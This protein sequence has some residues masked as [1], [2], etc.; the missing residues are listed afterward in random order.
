MKSITRYGCVAAALALVALMPVRAEAASYSFSTCLENNSGLC[1]TLVD[2]LHVEVTDAGGGFVDFKFTNDIGI[3]S[4]ITSLYFD[5]T[6]FLT[7]LSIQSQS[8][9]VKFKTTNVTPPN[10]PGAGGATPPFVLTSGL[11]TDSK[12]SGGGTSANGINA[13]TEY[14]TLRMAMAAGKT[15]D[16]I[17][18][19]LGKGDETDTGIRIAAHIQSVGKWDKS[20]SVL[21]CGAVTPTPVPEPGTLALCGVAALAAAYRRR[22]LKGLKA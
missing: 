6:G 21:C 3:S 13:A 8:S 11:S 19:A 20:D 1:E 5:A 10:V 16:D 15:F 7:S 9:G 14:L 17:K 12:S 2:Q 18:A 22:R 4:S